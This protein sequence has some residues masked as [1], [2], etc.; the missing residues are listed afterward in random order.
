LRRWH[1][2]FNARWSEAQA[3]GFDDRF[4]RMWNMYLTSCAGAFQGG[5]CDV[6]QV[7]LKRP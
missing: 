4:R 6:T 2:T 7:T 5:N 1:D 3:M